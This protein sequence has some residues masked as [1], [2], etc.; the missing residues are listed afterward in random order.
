MKVFFLDIDGTLASNDKKITD[1]NLSAIKEAQEKGN[2]VFINTGR[3]SSRLPYEISGIC[4]PDGIITSLGAT[5]K[6]GGKTVFSFGTTVEET[7][8]IYNIA[9]PSGWHMYFD[10]EYQ[11]YEINVPKNRIDRALSDP[12][13][14][15]DRLLAYS[16]NTSEFVITGEEYI[17]S[18]EIHLSK[19]V[20]FPEPTGFSQ[21]EKLSEFFNIHK[22][23]CYYD[24]ALKRC[25]KD[26]AI[27]KVCSLLGLDKKDTVA[28]GDS[29]NDISMLDYAEV[30]AVVKNASDSAKLH[31]DYISDK[32]NNESAVAEIIRKFI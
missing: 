7:I 5:I 21:V 25:G 27:Q 31:A 10:S 8:K 26:T 1:E 23:D 12:E 32:T 28:I 19:I 11:K 3:A 18:R 16:D 30:G 20:A 24:L 2:L 14:Q 9:L 4:N 13:N 22:T 17:K 15:R 6:I 29:E